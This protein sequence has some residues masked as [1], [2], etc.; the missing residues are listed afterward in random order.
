MS[1]KREMKRLSHIASVAGL[2]GLLEQPASAAR[3]PVMDTM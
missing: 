2:L 1:K 3:K